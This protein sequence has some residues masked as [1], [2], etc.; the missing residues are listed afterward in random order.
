LNNFSVLEA[1]AL[2]LMKDMDLTVSSVGEV[3]RTEEAAMDVA[4][5]IQIKLS[6]AA[7]VLGDVMVANLALI[8]APS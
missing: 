7:V 8:L 6:H 5:I 2:D 4:T 1:N 3:V